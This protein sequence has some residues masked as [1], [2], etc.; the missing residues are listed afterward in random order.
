M[1]R[2]AARQHF[3][4]QDDSSPTPDSCCSLCGI[5]HSVASY[6]EYGGLTTS[7][8]RFI[9]LHHSQACQSSVFTPS[10][11]LQF[12]LFRA[13][14]GP[15]LQTEPPPKCACALCT[16]QSNAPPPPIRVQVGAWVGIWPPFIND[17]GHAGQNR[18]SNVIK[19]PCLED[20]GWIFIILTNERTAI[21]AQQIKS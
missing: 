12:K 11:F 18:R 14:Q 17:P 3:I 1:V 16:Y 13:H 15:K 2:F 8:G 20:N 10:K 5:T 7:L 19:S 21:R 6:V 4:C 9:R